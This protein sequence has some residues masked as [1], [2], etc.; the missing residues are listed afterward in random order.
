M[1]NNHFIVGLGGTGGKVIRELLKAIERNKDP[2]GEVPSDA[3]F[4]FAYLD[5]S[6][7]LLH[8]T[9]QW[10]VLGKDVSLARPQRGIYAASGVRP[11]L[12]DPQSFPGMRDWIEPRR[13]FD[14]IDAG[15]AG[16]AQK[17]KLGRLVFAQNAKD[18]VRL[19]QDRL[20]QLKSDT[21]SAQATIHVVCGLAGGTGSGFVVDAVAQLRALCPNESDYR[22]VVYALLPDRGSPW[23]KDVAGHSAYYAN[24]YAALAE[25]N[26]MASR[27]YQPVNVL[28]GQRFDFSKYFNG[29]YLVNHVNEHK[30]SFDVKDEVP[31]IIAEFLYQKTLNKRWESLDRAERGE[32]DTQFI[33]KDDGIP[34]RA[35]LFMT[36]GIKRV[37]V[38]EQE[39]K[40]YMAYGFAEQASRQ[41][42]FNNFRQGEGYA[43]EA[44]ERDWGAEA[45]KA[46]ALQRFMLD[47]SHLTLDVAILE[48]DAKAGWKGI[49]EYWN[50]V[51]TQLEIQI[52][53]D[54][55][56]KESDWI[57][58]INNRM[59]VIFDDTYRRLGGVRKFYEVKDQARL[60]MARHIART[61]EKEFFLGWSSGDRSLLQLR[62]HADALLGYLAQR[63]KEFE[64]RIERSPAS[65]DKLEQ[66]ILASI[67]AFNDVGF[68]SRHLMS[69]RETHFTE[70]RERYQQLY[71]VRT[72]RE[73]LVFAVRLL[74]LLTEQI[75]S[76]RGRIDQ[77]H[78]ALDQ[79]TSHLN[80]ERSGRLRQDDDPVYQ[81]RIF[82][83]PSIDGLLRTMTIDESGQRARTQQ[84][85]KAII[86]LAGVEVDGFDRLVQR[87]TVGNLITTLIQQSAQI[88]EVTHAEL[89][90]ASA[91]V[92]HV[93][94]VERL[95]RRYGHNPTALRNFVTD[96]Y[97][98]AGSMVS[99]VDAEVN[100][101]LVG[102]EG[103]MS[104]CQ[105]AICV[106][107]P[108]S[109][110]QRE[111]RADLRRAFENEKDAG[112]EQAVLEGVL[113]N[114][115]VVMKVSSLMPVRFIQD[116]DFL[117]GH[118]DALL[119]NAD[120]AVLLHGEGDGSRLPPLFARTG[121]QV[122][123]LR[124]RKPNL[125]L[126]RLLGVLM[127]RDNP[128]SGEHEWFLRQTVDG[129][130]R[131]RVLAGGGDWN[132]VLLADQPEDLQT[133]LEKTVSASLASQF[134]HLEKKRALYQQFNDMVNARLEAV[135]FNEKD[136][137]Y[138]ALD[139]MG[140]TIRQLIKLPD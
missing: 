3:R 65:Q 88:T 19:F 59:G 60:D 53:S 38:P 1:S 52:K 35:K 72:L 44:L 61:I 140:L 75:T 104:G 86:G 71:T 108:E 43:N 33:E 89:A 131:I 133:A 129:R 92:L 134:Q 10:M 106:F 7:G 41:L 105:Q 122:Q 120:E 18:I 138:M 57:A 73:G 70:L 54:K 12:N 95:S 102:S 62:H 28:N 93:N 85:R 127:E 125:L 2:K 87:V 81:Q 13:V 49:R 21:K 109:E 139:A 76:L 9:D 110:A 14:F 11:V 58:T 116:L 96:L 30:V 121:I 82:D 5:T 20:A 31:R 50:Q 130:I 135:N 137:V 27:T 55:T 36:F 15:T 118:Y 67:R 136:A 119:R 40:E 114:E 112:T 47:D 79:A 26:G 8:E 107:L 63:K 25:L 115:V 4:E 103:S 101:M 22:I 123:A 78:Q 17:R 90:K 83:M 117:K 45:R 99:V 24:G 100:R 16:A 124:E 97:R 37:V 51:G 23:A 48:D 84:V 98:E 80:T 91:P 34:A 126:A 39:I 68:L 64:E 74:P 113:P 42:M 29:C 77:L 111:F 56:L 128:E 69:K 46:D 132:S 94:I 6:E 32:N 66:D